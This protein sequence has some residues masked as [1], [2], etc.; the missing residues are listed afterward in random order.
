MTGFRGRY[1]GVQL[2][3]A[4]AVL[5]WEIGYDF[6]CPTRGE[7]VAH[8]RALLKSGDRGRPIVKTSPTA[9]GPSGTGS[10]VAY[11]RPL[12]LLVV[13]KSL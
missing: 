5:N 10:G 2:G 13:D 11:G 7:N 4:S 6:S 3:V 1:P 9:Q 12:V 8:P